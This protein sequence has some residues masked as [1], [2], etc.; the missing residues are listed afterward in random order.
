MREAK[1][2]GL[3]ILAGL[4]IIAFFGC[5]P[6][7][8]GAGEVVGDSAI[9][10]EVKGRLVA[11]D[12]LSGLDVNVETF[13]RTVTLIGAVDTEEQKRAAE[14]VARSVDGVKDVNNLLKVR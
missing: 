3:I 7:G 9:S 11:D 12:R 6:A 8:R 14:E 5:A 1:R 2:V 10:A 4:L 13:E